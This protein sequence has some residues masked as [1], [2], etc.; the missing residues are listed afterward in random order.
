MTSCL[1]KKQAQLAQTN[2]GLSAAL[3]LATFEDSVAA[4]RAI[5]LGRSVSTGLGLLHT[6]FQSSSPSVQGQDE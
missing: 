4:A 3:Y 6:C 1:H 5:V 2:E